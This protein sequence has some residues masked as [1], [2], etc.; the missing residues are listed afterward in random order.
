[1]TYGVAASREPPNRGS[2]NRADFGFRRRRFDSFASKL[3]HARQQRKQLQ[4]LP[5]GLHGDRALLA[6]RLHGQPWT[7]LAVP[8][9]PDTGLQDRA[10]CPGPVPTRAGRLRPRVKRA[11]RLLD[12]HNRSSSTDSMEVA[13]KN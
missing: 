2:T 10:I 9:G 6:D 12:R 11:C 13:P 4:N 3:G 7:S 8:Q 5:N 1:M